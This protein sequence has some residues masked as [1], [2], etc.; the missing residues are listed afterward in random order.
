[1]LLMFV[2]SMAMAS[3]H[4]SAQEVTIT[5]MPGCNW[6]S[7]PNTEVMDI[8]TA[9]G[10]FVPME[11]DIIKSQFA[12]SY[13][14]NGLWRGGVTH[15][16]P[17]MGYHYYSARTENIEFTFV[18]AS[19]SSVTTAEPT[20]ITAMSA[21]AGG[22]VDVPEGSHVFLRGVCWGAEP[23][24]DIDGNHTSD[25][26]GTG[27]FSSTLDSLMPSTTYYVRAYVVSDS[28]LNYGNEMSFT[29]LEDGD[30]HEYVDLGLPSGTLWATCNVGA[31]TPEEYGDYF[32]WGETQT[33]STYN[34][35]T[36]Q[37]QSQYCMGG[38]NGMLT[39]YCNDSS[40]GYNGYTDTLTMLLPEDDAA[41][42]NWSSDW[43]MPTKE[44]WQELYNNTTD[45]WTT[46]NGVNGRLF[47]ASN[48][49]SLFL[50][51][52]GSRSEDE[53]YDAG[54]YGTYWSSSLYT[55]Y[56]V[57]A[58]NFDI[59]PGGGYTGMENGYVR[60]CG[61]SVRAVRSARQN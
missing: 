4:A 31:T 17:G 36:Y 12:N 18:Q 48:G 55:D 41:T 3:H 60:D 29:T 5:L 19:Y 37:Y 54:Y 24:P 25:G 40:Y 1:M 46:Q 44:E 2:L 9:L 20:D 22:M 6:I 50:P 26:T 43:R 30:N 7:Y 34:W 45:T 33:K 39:K 8:A 57:S 15:F 42:A 32:A 27:S 11:G 51:A 58:W 23:N 38:G 16:M 52:A 14:R 56:P 47:T 53:L 21:V 35:N 28:G 10:D 13:Y 49:N 61:L 59:S